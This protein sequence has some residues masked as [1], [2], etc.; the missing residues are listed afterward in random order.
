MFTP[1][2]AEVILTEDN[3]IEMKVQEAVKIQVRSRPLKKTIGLSFQRYT[4]P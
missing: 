2:Y 1:S 4:K 3:I